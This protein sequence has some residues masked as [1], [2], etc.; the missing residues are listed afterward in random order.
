[1]SESSY[2]ESFASYVLSIRAVV[3]I[4]IRARARV[5]TTVSYIASSCVV[6]AAKTTAGR[7]NLDSDRPR[8]DR[9]DARVAKMGAYRGAIN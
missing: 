2:R 9:M 8:E 3:V 6:V 5:P 4:R 1:M 7:T